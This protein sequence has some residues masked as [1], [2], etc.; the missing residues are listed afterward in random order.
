MSPWVRK[1][2][3]QIMPKILLMERPKYIPRY[4][5]E[6]EN[7][8]SVLEESC[9]STTNT[10]HST[11]SRRHSNK[12]NGHAGGLDLCKFEEHSGREKREVLLIYVAFVPQHGFSRLRRFE[13]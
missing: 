1:V 7:K 12:P 3:I 5:A 13:G 6:P 11:V 2:F 9:G 4:S 10:H 8:L